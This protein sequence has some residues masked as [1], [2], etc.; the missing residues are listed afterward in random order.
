M[1]DET[2][3]GKRVMNTRLDVLRR[4]TEITAACTDKDLA[5]QLSED[6]LYGSPASFWRTALGAGLVT[7]A[8]YERARALVGGGWNY[9]GD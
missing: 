8:E 5:R 4:Q 3:K 6:N 2:T 1:T 9:R 7:Q